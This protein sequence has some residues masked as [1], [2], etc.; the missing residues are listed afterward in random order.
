MSAEQSL[1]AYQFSYERD[2]LL[3]ALETAKG[4]F[5]VAFLYAFEISGP[6]FKMYLGILIQVGKS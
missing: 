5:L 3:V 2:P 6:D 4:L 1:L